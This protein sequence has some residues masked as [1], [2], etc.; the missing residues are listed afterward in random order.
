MQ[1]LNESEAIQNTSW[2]FVEGMWA[3]VKSKN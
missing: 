2:A 3:W 1:T